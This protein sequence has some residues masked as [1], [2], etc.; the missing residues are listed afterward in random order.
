[1]KYV[2]EQNA[3]EK[4]HQGLS[5][6]PIHRSSRQVDYSLDGKNEEI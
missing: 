3:P 1:M 6:K 2:M 4:I 5:Q